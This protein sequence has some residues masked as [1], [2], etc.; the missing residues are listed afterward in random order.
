LLGAVAL[1]FEGNVVCRLLR[2]GRQQAEGEQG[3]KAYWGH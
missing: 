2:T 3:D 1:V